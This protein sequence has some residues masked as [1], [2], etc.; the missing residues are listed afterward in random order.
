MSRRISKDSGTQ[1][2]S[3]YVSPYLRL[4]RRTLDDVLRQRTRR[5]AKG[6]VDRTA[7]ESKEGPDLADARR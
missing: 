6:P 5:L 4:P 3:T 2:D 1:T 7:N